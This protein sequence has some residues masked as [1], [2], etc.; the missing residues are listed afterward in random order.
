MSTSTTLNS[1]NGKDLQP[2]LEYELGK[3]QKIENIM[4]TEVGVKIFRVFEPAYVSV[5]KMRY[6]AAFD[7]GHIDGLVSVIKNF[8]NGDRSDLKTQEIKCNIQLY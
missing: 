2:R 4:A 5:G 8:I 6:P 3:G 1:K 7:H